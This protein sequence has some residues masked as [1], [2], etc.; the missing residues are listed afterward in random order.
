M[1]DQIDVQAIRKRVEKRFKQRQEFMIHL[2]VFVITNVGLWGLWLLLG[3]GFAWPAIVTMGWGIGLL[4]H[5]ITVYTEATM[6]Q[7]REEM[8]DREIRREKMRVYGDPDY[9]ESLLS[10]PKR[11]G[12]DPA[13]RLTDDGEIVAAEDDLT[14][15]RVSRKKG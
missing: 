2:A 8:I 3:G 14:S 1:T 5:G 13:L 11:G 12:N 4:I 9:D 6:E 15:K 10:K 7:R